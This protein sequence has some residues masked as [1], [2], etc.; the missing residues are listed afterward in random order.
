MI[1]QS[2]RELLAAVRGGRQTVDAAVARL[3]SLPFEDLGFAKVDHHRSIRCG[4]P[5]VVYC[6]GKTVQQCAEIFE[7][8]ARQGVNVLATRASA[9]VFDAIASRHAAAVYHEAA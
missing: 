3:R 2:L 1:E 5:E 6:A 8:C 7:R 9:E 4:F